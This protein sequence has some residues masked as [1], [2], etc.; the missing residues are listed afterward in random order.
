MGKTMRY[1]E[2]KHFRFFCNDLHINH[3]E[4]AGV[5]V[6]HMPLRTLK[7]SALVSPDGKGKESG[8]NLTTL[9]CMVRPKGE[10]EQSLLSTSNGVSSYQLYNTELTSSL[11]ENV[12]QN[13][14]V[15]T[16]LLGG[17]KS[18]FIVWSALLLFFF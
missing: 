13:Y 1:K 2:N 12:S 7:I 15:H 9:P 16:I 18:V 8:H 10:R 5:G 3:N 17:V 14:I 6:T 11:E 4:T